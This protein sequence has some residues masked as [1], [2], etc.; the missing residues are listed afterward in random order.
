MKVI[1]INLSVTSQQYADLHE[2]ERVDLRLNVNDQIGDTI[3]LY[4]IEGVK[5]MISEIY[6]ENK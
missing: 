6:N 1:D 3:R 4:P 5:A 2:A